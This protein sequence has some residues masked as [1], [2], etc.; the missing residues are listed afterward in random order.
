MCGQQETNEIVDTDKRFTYEKTTT[1]NYRITFLLKFLRANNNSNGR[2]W[3]GLP[4]PLQSERSKNE[5][6][7]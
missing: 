2:V 1:W 4:N 6:N 7:F 3:W 5:T